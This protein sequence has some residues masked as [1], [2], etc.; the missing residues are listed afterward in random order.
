MARDLNSLLIAI[1][2]AHSASE[3]AGGERIITNFR[4]D[5]RL[6]KDHTLK[7]KVESVKKR[8]SR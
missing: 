1:F 2:A 7:D 4:I 6:D 3:S 8:I 5:E